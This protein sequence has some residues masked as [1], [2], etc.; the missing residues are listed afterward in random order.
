MNKTSLSDQQDPSGIKQTTHAN[1]HGYTIWLI[2]VILTAILIALS[3]W[4]WNG[5]QDSIGAR[6]QIIVSMVGF[7]GSIV[8]SLLYHHYKASGHQWHGRL[9]ISDSFLHHLLKE[10]WIAIICAGMSIGALI[11]AGVLFLSLPH[12][13]PPP[14]SYGCSP[15]PCAISRDGQLVG[16]SDGL[17]HFWP[18]NGPNTVESLIYQEDNRVKEPG[19]NYITFIVVTTLSDRPDMIAAD[20][21][22]KGIGYDDLQGAY[23]LQMEVNG[24]GGCPLPNSNCLK[25]RLLVANVG[26]DAEHALPVARQIVDLA[27]QDKTIKGVMGWPS[28]TS[29]ALAGVSY[30]GSHHILMIS[31]SASSDK[32]TNQPL[33]TR[34][35]P[36]DSQQGVLGAQ[37][38]ATHFPDAQSV[39]VFSAPDNPYSSTLEEAFTKA[40][41]K[42]GKKVIPETYKRMDLKYQRD[43]NISLDLQNAIHNSAQLIYFTGYSDDLNS[44]M[45]DLNSPGFQQM[46]IPVIAGDA[47]YDLSG[48]SGK[49]YQN[50]F[51]TA[52]AFP[53]QWGDT[54][55]NPCA[56]SQSPLF[57]EYAAD[58]DPHHQHPGQ[59]GFSRVDSNVMLSYDALNMLVHASINT[60]KKV[61]DITPKDMW[62]ELLKLRSFPGASGSITLGPDGNPIDKPMVIL[63]V[64]SDGRASKPTVCQQSKGAW[65]CP[66]SS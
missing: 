1:G 65:S 55:K 12:Q 53:D 60:G 35:V 34:V 24:N 21:S 18:D 43:E 54:S 30:L 44:L 66:Q 9:E 58:F 23:V 5:V 16:I 38:V 47:A 39:A 3:I 32:L 11:F 17:N 10:Y 63:Y 27:R 2:I 19:A 15:A 49:G 4:T 13:P 50:L 48:Y 31:P 52:F 45:N 62:N 36:P 25:I 20:Q 59:Y 57:C 46:K 7:Y 61:E 51:F 40:V 8:G 41:G 26:F 28:S 22:E 37:F 33:F 64:N 14:P 29:D 42:F 6:I 56:V